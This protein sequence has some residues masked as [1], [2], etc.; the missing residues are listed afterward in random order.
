[1]QC[2]SGNISRRTEEGLMLIKVSRAWTCDMTAADVAVC[3]IA[4]GVCLNGRK[5]S[6][7]LGFHA[8]ILRERPDVN[9]VMHV[10]TP[11][12]T[13]MA[14]RD[15]DGVDFFVIPEIPFYIGE[16]AEVPYFP[17]GSAELAAAVVAAMRDHNLALLRNHGQITAAADFDH[18]IQNAIFFELA[19]GVILDAGPALRPLPPEAVR[20]LL[21]AA[22]HAGPV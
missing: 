4:D 5:P 21:A 19:C 11:R 9:V 8:G 14:C 15:L 2:S 6:V 13:A 12:A 7:E 3:R 17:P 16:I 22:R 10:Q 18:A 20:G 1:M